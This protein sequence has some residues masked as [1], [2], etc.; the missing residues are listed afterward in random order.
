MSHLFLRSRRSS[1]IPVKKHERIKKIYCENKIFYIPSEVYTPSDDTYLL[2]DNL[3]VDGGDRVLDMGTGCGIIGIITA[4][5]VQKVLA[6]DINPHAIRCAYNNAKINNVLDK[7]ETREGDLFKVV[8]SFEGF[9][10][11]IFNPPY[12]QSPEEESDLGWIQKAW[13]GG[14]SG[15]DTVDRFLEEFDQYLSENGRILMVQSTLSDVDKTVNRLRKSGF[16][17][18]IIDEKKLAFEKL[19]VIQA[20]R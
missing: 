7:F 12:L 18:N 9:N 13:N 11:I 4:K 6:I 10:L 19:V 2:I 16:D 1:I 3:K 5:K 8:N 20:N 14:L 17:V 15:R